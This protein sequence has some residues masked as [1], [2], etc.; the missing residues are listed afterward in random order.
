MNKDLANRQVAYFSL[1][2]NPG[3]SIQ[4]FVDLLK[5][6]LITD[7]VV[8]AHGLSKEVIDSSSNEE[9]TEILEEKID[10][11]LISRKFPANTEIAL[12]INVGTNLTPLNDEKIDALIKVAEALTEI[13]I[14][15]FF[16]GILMD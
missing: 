15:L 7:S 12:A 10:Y 14:K 13:Q 11:S 6:G 8:E 3:K 1:W 5:R 16:P 2:Y 4:F 9:L